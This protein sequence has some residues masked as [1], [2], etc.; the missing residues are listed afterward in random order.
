MKSPRNIRFAPSAVAAL[1]FL[2]S[3]TLNS[4]AHAHFVWV[5]PEGS[6][7]KVVF[8]EGLKPDDAQYL[9]S[10]KTM[11][12]YKVVDGERVLIE[13][14]KQTEDGMGWFETPVKESGGIVD[15]HVPYGVFGRG[16]KSMLLDYSAKFLNTTQ[17]TSAKP[18]KKLTLD[19]VPSF[20][21]GQLK[22]AAYLNGYPI[23]GVEVEV[24]R[25]ESD[26]SVVT[27]DVS[28]HALVAPNGRYII[29]GKHVV[30]E[31]GELDGKK[32]D[33]KRY[34]CTL[35]METSPTAKTDSKTEVTDVAT[36]I[37][38]GIKLQ[39]VQT[40]LEDFPRGMTSFGAAVVGNQ[41][42]VIGGKSGR[43]HAYARSYQNTSVFSLATDGSN[44]QWQTVSENL[45]LQG[46]AIV[47]Y[48]G[49]VYRIGGLEARNKEDEDDDLH[50]VADFK[51]FDPTT[52]TWT[53]LPS[54]PEG[55]S[56]IDA[57]VVGSNVYVVG[58]WTMG[59]DDPVWATTMLKFDLSNPSGE[60][61]KLDVPFKTRALA[62]EAHNDH[63]VAVGGLKEDG[64]PTG[65]VFIYDLKSNKWS[66]GP[67]VPTT[68]GMKAF[69][70]STTSVAG[71]VLTSTY[72]GGIYELA[73]D[74]SGWAKVHQLDN[75]RFFHQMLALADNRFALVGGAHMET[76]GNTDIE[77]FEATA[78]E[79]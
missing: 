64:G 51:Q 13:M 44:N 10:L 72:D 69:G 25:L 61:V 32:Y 2:F 45:G 76:G 11:K 7:V 15:V 41:I 50:S 54:L 33:E 29:R 58:G 30:A 65:E 12:A 22:I 14:K 62:V 40:E 68:G 26:K 20:E 59:D 17:G 49:K 39:P 21:N 1:F 46:L 23:E 35:V 60:W 42:V 31:A 66:P 24:E 28:G 53:D 74:N 71:R 77:V 37:E 67:T 57:C 16:D 56:S 27:T 43:A 75:G 48:G 63:L 36:A 52:K 9:S 4:V 3:L 19:L 73:S 78:N 8:G 34:Y 5:Y 6:Q 38:A 18:S 79:K 70:C 47:E 55:R